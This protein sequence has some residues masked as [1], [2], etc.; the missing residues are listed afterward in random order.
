MKNHHGIEMK[1][2]LLRL[3]KRGLLTQTEA[4]R[5]GNT[6]RQRVFQWARQDGINPVEARKQYLKRL[7]DNGT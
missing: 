6:S 3:L 1:E 2:K 5:L 4:A 7:M